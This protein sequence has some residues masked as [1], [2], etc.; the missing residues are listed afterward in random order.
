VVASVTAVLTVF[1]AVRD[2]STAALVIAGGCMLLALVAWWALLGWKPTVV[3][4]REGVLDVTR[5]GHSET[6]ELTD[7]ATAVNFKGRPG[8]PGWAATIRN[9][10]GPRT[11]LR[12]SHVK[13]RQFERIVRHYRSRTEASASEETSA[14]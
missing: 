12:S 2:S 13:P 3:S 1:V 9:G 6:F 4:I 14:D 8:T 11:V 10:N 5:G 7:P